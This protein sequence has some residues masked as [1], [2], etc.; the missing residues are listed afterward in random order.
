MVCVGRP[1]REISFVSQPY[2][3]GLRVF[4]HVCFLYSRL[5]IITIEFRVCIVFRMST[6]ISI[7]LPIRRG[8][9]QPADAADSGQGAAP[10]A[11][12][13]DQARK[14]ALDERADAAHS[15][16]THSGCDISIRA[17]E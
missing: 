7:S 17:L 15:V 5:E 8:R 16:L 1:V 2:A 3:F 10:V 6:C 13:N 12:G 14:D 11:R 4:L 9:C